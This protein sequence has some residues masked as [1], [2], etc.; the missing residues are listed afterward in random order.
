MARAFIGCDKLPDE[1]RN[2]FK[3][4]GIG[5]LNVVSEQRKNF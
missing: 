3:K 2:G 5:V 1:P 4:V